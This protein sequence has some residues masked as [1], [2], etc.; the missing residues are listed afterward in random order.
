MLTSCLA[1]ETNHE[2]DDPRCGLPARSRPA[3][4]TRGL[5]G[6]RGGALFA[7]YGRHTRSGPACH[8][9]RRPPRRGTPC[10][11]CVHRVGADHVGT[12]LS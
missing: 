3:T 12:S 11:V 2:R 10:D 8:P 1:W 7:R 5:M 9:S 6:R 4:R